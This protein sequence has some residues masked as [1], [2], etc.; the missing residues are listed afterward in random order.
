MSDI[1]TI[2]SNIRQSG[3]L[4]ILFVGSGISK[5]YT[6]NDYNW[7]QLLIRCISEYEEEPLKKYLSYETQALRETNSVEMTEE[8]YT[9]IGSKVEY[10]FNMA[11]YAGEIDMDV[12]EENNVS[13]LKRFISETLSQYSI[14]VEL[15]SE[16]ELLKELHEK[17]LTVVTTNYDSFLEDH[18][19]TSHRAVIGA[20]I[21]LG[22]EIGTLVKMHGCVT[23]PESITLTRED[24][25]RLDRRSRVLV[26]KLIHLFTE[27]PVIFLGYSLTDASIQKLL[28]DIYGCVESSLDF[29][30]LK[31]RLI[32]VE[33]DEEQSEPDVGEFVK[34]V[35]GRSIHLTRIRLSDYTILLEHMAQM[36]RITKLKEVFW[37]KNLVSDL[38]INYQGNKTKII[39]LSDDE[40]GYSG[41]EVV[42]AIGKEK[43]MPSPLQDKGLA[44]LEGKDFYRDIVFDDMPAVKSKSNLLGVLVTLA[45]RNS[46]VLPVHKYLKGFDGEVDTK[47]KAIQSK[48]PKDVL[49]KTIE[50]DFSRFEEFIGEH[51][52]ISMEEI[53]K[54]DIPNVRKSNFL[55]LKAAFRAET[56]ELRGFLE[57]HFDDIPKITGSTTNLRK[58]ILLL[59]MKENKTQQGTA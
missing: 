20:P 36:D 41:D 18:I 19:F 46:N 38:V 6:T 15:S 24:Y 53:Y 4:P 31:E 50:K 16:I 43:D 34:N 55:V 13:P 28:A 21:F 26:G 25:L 48:E 8:V 56:Q 23:A 5:R 58:M 59:D 3:R 30:R 40:D 49:N 29:R 57:Q 9:R 37:L 22:S 27:N 17:M 10:D 45:K 35:D 1:A 51:P 52:E 7:R 14:K 54:S 11:V 39:Q 32:F 33:Y 47:L 42:V 12:S 44:G 2:F